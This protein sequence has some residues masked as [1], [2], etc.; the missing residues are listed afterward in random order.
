MA[1]RCA[2]GPAGVVEIERR[3]LYRSRWGF[4]PAGSGGKLD[5][6]RSSADINPAIIPSSSDRAYKNKKYGVEYLLQDRTWLAAVLIHEFTHTR[7]WKTYVFKEEEAWDV[8]YKFLMRVAKA[9]NLSSS[10]KNRIYFLADK[11]RGNRDHD[12]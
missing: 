8:T 5:L 2:T 9:P 7:Q 3:R 10:E 1:G 4:H 12:Q 11:A 6:C